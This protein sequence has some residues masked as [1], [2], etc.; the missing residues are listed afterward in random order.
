MDNY[1]NNMIMINLKKSKAEKPKRKR[2]R[3][4]IKAIKVATTNG[5]TYTN[6]GG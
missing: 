1:L 3:K 5:T 2:K 4:S 6:F